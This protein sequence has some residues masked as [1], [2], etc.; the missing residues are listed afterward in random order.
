LTILL[1][2]PDFEETGEEPAVS[3]FAFALRVSMTAHLRV[4]EYGGP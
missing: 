3:H 2:K 1:G 4:Q